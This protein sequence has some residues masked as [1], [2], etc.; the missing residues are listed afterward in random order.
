MKKA[1]DYIV[2]QIDFRG[3]AEEWQD[4][5]RKIVQLWRTGLRSIYLQRLEFEFEVEDEKLPGQVIG[6][7]KGEG[8]MEPLPA[9]EA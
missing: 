3:S 8:G 2:A 4:Y 5:C 9:Y 1:T 6:K 7:E